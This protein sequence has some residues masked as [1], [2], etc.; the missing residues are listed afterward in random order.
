MMGKSRQIHGIAIVNNVWV[1]TDFHIGHSKIKE[2]CL[3]PD[4]YEELIL[5]NLKSVVKSGDTVINLG[6][7]LLGD[8]SLLKPFICNLSKEY[9]HF[10]CTH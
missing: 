10:K 1:T 2:Y 6:D 8:H 4:N 7:V 3:R 5:N 9:P